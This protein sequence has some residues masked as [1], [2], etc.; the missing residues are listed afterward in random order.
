MF[1]RKKQQKPEDATQPVDYQRLAQEVVKEQKRLSS[2]GSGFGCASLIILAAMTY[3]VAMTCPECVKWASQQVAGIIPSAT[4]V[5]RQTVYRQSPTNIP[6]ATPTVGR[7]QPVTPVPRQTTNQS[8]KTTNSVI[9]PT[10]KAVKSQTYLFH[11]CVNRGVNLRTG[12]GFSE[13]ALAGEMQPGVSYG[14]IATRKGESVQGNKTW[15][16]VE[17]PGKTAFVTAHYTFA[18]DLPRVAT[19]AQRPSTTDPTAERITSCKDKNLL[20]L[21]RSSLIFSHN[22]I[23]RAVAYCSSI[24]VMVE[25]KINAVFDTLNEA[26]HEM[27]A[28]QCALRQNEYGITFDVLTD[29]VDVAGNNLESRA[30][31]ARYEAEMTNQINCDSYYSA[32]NWEAAASSW[33][34]HRALND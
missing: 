13:F 31:L 22:E 25:L 10:S 26:K 19:S 28:L 23:R 5:N 7:R 1:G 2:S 4:Q 24:Q 21:A 30:V 32:V 3:L 20:S 9:P 33:W 15:Y 18:C 6:R 34:V 27:Y 29:F 8:S 14:V 12:A 11:I 16:E 17:H